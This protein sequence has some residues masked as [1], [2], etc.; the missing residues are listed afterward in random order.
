MFTV[1]EKNSLTKDTGK[2]ILGLTDKL[3]QSIFVSADTERR[4]VSITIT[5][6][7]VFLEE[8]IDKFIIQIMS[9][10]KNGLI[11]GNR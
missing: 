5:N 11:P 6:T 4:T 7:T 3:A 2:K 9:E 8:K 1:Q 10:D